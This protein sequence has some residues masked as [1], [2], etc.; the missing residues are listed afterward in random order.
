MRINTNVSSLQAQDAN[1]NT[2]KTLSSSLEKLST[3]LKINKAADDASGLAIADK[4]RTQASSIGQGISNA[5]SASALIQIAD[6]AMGEQSNILDTVK[7]KLIQAATATTTEAGREAIRKDITKLLDQVDEIAKQTNYNGLTLLQQSATDTAKAD[8]FTFQLGEDSTF[9]VSLTQT[10]ASNT[11]SLGGGNATVVSAALNV[12]A[13]DPITGVSS[14]T[15]NNIGVDGA[16][17]TF[18]GAGTVTLNVTDISS[19]DVETTSASATLDITVSGSIGKVH[20]D[21]VGTVFDASNQTQAVK[22]I[23][24]AIATGNGDF[25][26]AGDTYTLAAGASVSF[27]TLEFSGIQ[28]TNATYGASIQLNAGS[29]TVDFSVINNVALAG[30]PNAGQLNVET[31]ATMTG[32]SLLSDIKNLAENELTNALANKYMSTVDEAITQLNT[33]RAD[34][35]SSQNQIESSLRSMQTTQV[36]LKAAES[37]IRDVDYAAESANFNKQ[38]IVAQAGTYAM[39]Q[40]NAVSQNVLRLLQ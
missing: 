15:G 26:K 40:A 24:D 36:N 3:G 23:L 4:L 11:L 20:G 9:D 25:T 39:S 30:K 21:A 14:T 38:N 8:A 34:F 29:E 16:S 35:G 37:V 13:T 22:D 7:S 18:S 27:G 17:Q 12:A 1:S 31:G 2:N 19:A 6:K 10:N 33:N 28:I 5:N 32:G